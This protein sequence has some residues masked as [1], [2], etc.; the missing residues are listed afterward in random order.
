MIQ[1][2]HIS[3]PIK[4]KIYTSHSIPQHIQ[5]QL[6]CKVTQNH[7]TLRQIRFYDDVIGFLCKYMLLGSPVITVEQEEHTQSAH[8]TLHSE[9]AK[10]NE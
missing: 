4:L 6:T 3:V 5:T 1:S 2:Y 8:I 7:C 9:L 10:F